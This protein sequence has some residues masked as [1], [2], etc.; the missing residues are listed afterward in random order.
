MAAIKHIFNELHNDN[1]QI[2]LTCDRPPKSLSLM[3]DR[4][5]SRF[6]WGL[7]ADVQPP[8]LETRQAILAT[9]ADVKGIS[10]PRDVLEFVARKVRR[11]IRELEGALNRVIACAEY[12]HTPLSV[13]LAAKALS[14]MP[15]EAPWK[16]ITPAQ[17]VGAVADYYK[18]LAEAMVSPK[19]EKPLTQARQ[20]AMYILREDVG[21]TLAEIGHVLGGRD[22]KTIHHGYGRIASAINDDLQLREDVLEIRDRLLRRSSDAA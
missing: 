11:N 21:L 7:I 8:D 16:R 6:E 17:V 2:V 9:K 13:E 20:V 18:L 12:T 4:L 10:V 3:E 22:H 5:R 1:R 15:G 19:R 14:E